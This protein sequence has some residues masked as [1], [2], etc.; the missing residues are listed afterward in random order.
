MDKST[1]GYYKHLRSKPSKTKVRR[2]KTKKAIVKIY[3][4][5]HQIYGSPKI[6]VILHKHGIQGCQKYVY[7][8]MKE[9][10]IKPKYL[11]HK[12]KTTISKGND[13]KL[14]NLLK[15]QFNPKDPDS[16]WC[17]DIMVLCQV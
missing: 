5:S 15:R 4:D 11:K 9:A 17:T 10:N 6:A 16:V 14:H 7:S 13:R 12:I 8:I 3:N 2:E 1:S